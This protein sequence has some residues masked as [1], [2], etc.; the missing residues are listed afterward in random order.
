MLSAGQFVILDASEEACVRIPGAASQEAEYLY[1][2]LSGDGTVS[3]NGTAAAY[4]LQGGPSPSASVARAGP[5]LAGQGPVPRRRAS[6][7]G[8]ASGSGR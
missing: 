4:Q 3:E 8:C 2:A 5:G 1:V 7:T 6:T